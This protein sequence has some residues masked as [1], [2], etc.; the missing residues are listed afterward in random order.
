MQWRNRALQ[1]Y[2]IN[3]RWSPAVY[4]ARGTLGFEEDELKA[5]A[6]EGYPGGDVCY[7]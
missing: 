3:Y 1:M 2:D 7:G 4:D 6:Y 5:R